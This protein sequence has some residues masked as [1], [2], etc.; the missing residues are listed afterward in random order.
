MG[1]FPKS[2]HLGSELSSSA[3]L[4]HRAVPRGVP[5]LGPLAVCQEELEWS[6]PQEGLSGRRGQAGRDISLQVS[7]Q[8]LLSAMVSGRV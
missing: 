8:H 4:S 5:A 2:T 7:P 6:G 3:F 1:N